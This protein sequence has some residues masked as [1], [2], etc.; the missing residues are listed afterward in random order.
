M[1]PLRTALFIPALLAA[2]GCAVRPS[3]TYRLTPQANAPVL[4]PPGV[5]TPEVSR[6]GFTMMLAKGRPCPSGGTAI[7]VAAHGGKLRVSV[8]RD[9]LLQQPP[10][11]LRRWSAE[12][13]SQGCIPLGTGLPFAMRIL[14]SVPLDPTA[15][16]RLLHADSMGQGY[17]ELGA[18]NRLQTMAPILKAG[19]SPDAD[20]ILEIASVTG[21][22]TSLTMDLRA[23]DD[24]LGV[25]TS[26]YAL[27]PKA[28]GAG[29]TIV[30]LSAA[31][32]IDGKTEAAAAPLRDYFQFAREI[33]FY[34]LIY[35]ADV[36][37]KGTLT[38]IVVGA[39]DRMELD[40]RTQLVLND[41]DTCK[42]SDPSLCAVIP[43][44]VAVNPFLAVTVN[45]EETRLGVRATVRGAILQGRGP[46]RAEE[47]L[48][49]LSVR[50]PYGG[51]LVEVEFDRSSSAILDM[52][53][54]GGESISWK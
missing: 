1:S 20:V 35:K 44:H 33:G 45:G 11:W 39:P 48:P 34:R 31:R 17:V 36:T 21:S 3:Q 16:Y 6:G 49:H 40:R 5:A 10:G 9:A 29:T 18:E 15:A 23:S 27:R 13:E 54:L 51:K 12:L 19:K 52:L 43:R 8:S 22:G 47:V 46:Q 26:W 38:E 42:I 25:E 37:D 24:L 7:A 32:T 41:F 53:L 2:S 50:K 4:V 14:Q 30:P 28:D